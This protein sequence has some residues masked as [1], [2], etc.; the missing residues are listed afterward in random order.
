MGRRERDGRSAH[1]KD[2]RIDRLSAEK[3]IFRGPI[4][5]DPDSMRAVAQNL[6]RQG[7]NFREEENLP[8]EIPVTLENKRRLTVMTTVFASFADEVLEVDVAARLPDPSRYYFSRG[9]SLGSKT[10]HKEVIGTR[11]EEASS[12]G[13]VHVADTG[14]IANTFANAQHGLVHEASAT[15]VELTEGGVARARLNHYEGTDGE[16][17]IVNEVVT[18]LTNC[19][20]RVFDWG[21]YP[22]LA[23]IRS[24]AIGYLDQ[25]LVGEL[26]IKAV[27]EHHGQSYVDL[28][29]SLQRGMVLGDKNSLDPIAEAV[30]QDR[31]RTLES[32]TSVDIASTRRV[33]DDLGLEEAREKLEELYAGRPVGLMSS[34]DGEPAIT[35]RIPKN[36]NKLRA[37]QKSTILREPLSKE[38]NSARIQTALL[39]DGVA[40]NTHDEDCGV[41]ASQQDIP[42]S[43]GEQPAIS[44][45]ETEA[46]ASL[47]DHPVAE[48]RSEDRLTAFELD[49]MYFDSSAAVGTPGDGTPEDVFHYYGLEQNSEPPAERITAPEIEE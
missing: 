34:F 33:I 26:L 47:T 32:W 39:P 31:M 42:F 20:L 23:D 27:A 36:G 12:L 25:T 48:S 22:E 24:G 43:Q 30:G 15:V 7:V 17:C 1:Q 40:Y 19:E 35:T 3:L 5:Q 49:H 14:N 18:E 2:V 28:L 6:Y 21:D 4:T 10:L 16:L 44:S 41:L 46:S 9:E 37:I 11:M 29:R 13:Y 45:G 38:D 8:P